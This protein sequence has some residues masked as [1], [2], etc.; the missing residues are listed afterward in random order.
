MEV[1]K[2]SNKTKRLLVEKKNSFWIWRWWILLQTQTQIRL[3]LQ[4]KKLTVATFFFFFWIVASP[5]MTV[6]KAVTFRPLW[7]LDLLVGQTWLL[8]EWLRRVRRVL[9][10][11]RLLLVFVQQ[12]LQPTVA[13]MR[14]HNLTPTGNEGPPFA[15]KFYTKPK[16]T[17]PSPASFCPQRPCCWS[18]PSCPPCPPS[19]CPSSSCPRPRRACCGTPRCSPAPAGVG[20]CP[21]HGFW[22]AFQARSTWCDTVRLWANQGSGLDTTAS[23]VIF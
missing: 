9:D 11:L 8:V 13:K 2:D 16:Q 23:N 17:S 10:D 6:I 14:R 15:S 12:T 18:C 22:P 4:K 5:S 21:R 3:S 7:W 1:W 20:P 19:S